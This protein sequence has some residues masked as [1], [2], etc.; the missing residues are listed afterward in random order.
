MLPVLLQRAFSC[1]VSDCECVCGRTGLLA[2]SGAFVQSAGMCVQ[3]NG[4]QR[5][6]AALCAGLYEYRY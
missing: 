1:T 6:E 4:R 5:C 2:S 3:E